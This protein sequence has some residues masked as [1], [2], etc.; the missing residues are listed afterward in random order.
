MSLRCHFDKDGWLQGPVKITHMTQLTPNR[1]NSGF[2]AKARGMVQ[3]TEDGFE[4]GTVDT[5][6]NAHAQASAF[7]SV[8]EAGDA[9][10]YLPVGHGYVAWAQEHGNPEWYSCE[11]EDKT[12]TSTPMPPPQLTAIAQIFEALSER[13][14]FPLAITDDTVSGHGLITHGDGGVSWGNHPNCPGSVRRAQRPKIIALAM[15]IRAEGSAPKGPFRHTA[16]GGQTLAQIAAARGTTAQHL[17]GVSAGAYTDRD[18]TV[19]AGLPL[20][21]GAPY[22]TSAP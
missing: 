4:G 20:P 2:A 17:A 9:H 22:Y 15:S 11:A 8:S 3:H 18:V 12:K 16:P 21:A 7:F 1:Y 6:M 10:Q 19:L 13:D 14:G 5:F